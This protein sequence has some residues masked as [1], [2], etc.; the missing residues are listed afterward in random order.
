MNSR[1]PDNGMPVPGQSMKATKGKQLT[2]KKVL[3]EGGQGRV[4]LVDYD[5]SEKAFKW[6][7]LGV[8]PNPNAFRKNLV[9]NAES[10]SPA[11]QF[12]WPID[13]VENDDGRFGYVME[14]RPPE[15]REAIEFFL[16]K[17]YFAN[18]KRAIDACLNVV[19]AFRLLHNKG[20]VYRDINGGNFFINP[21]NGKVLICDND[22]VGDPTIDTGIIGT[23]RFMAPEVV[24]GATEPNTKSD[25]YSMSV[26]LFM[27]LCLN[28]PLEG[29]RSLIPVLDRA[30]QK[31]LYGTDPIFIMDPDNKANPP[32]P[33]VHSNVICM[34]G[35]LPGYMRDLF[36][37]AFSR[38][39]L[40]NPQKRP[41]EFEWINTL[42]RFRSD[43]VACRCGNEVFLD[44]KASSMCEICGRTISPACK[45]K[46]ANYEIPI[47][48]D[49]RIYKCQIAICS[50]DEALKPIAQ[51]IT[52]KD[53]PSFLG[54]LN[55]SDTTWDAV[56][57]SGK[58]KLVQPDD[59][60]PVIPG[61]QFTIEST[62]VQI[63]P[64]QA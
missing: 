23:P 47:A 8:F 60:I 33:Q 34:W 44:E 5:G 40:F 56:T 25:I 54:I 31:M 39:A 29:E 43:I 37:R 58:K 17:V 10:P 63:Q 59:I 26:L 20:F 48:H 15:Y 49:S 6:Y 19:S 55:M 61:I 32:D 21:A 24:T 52:K 13:I 11:R 2:V 18:F 42:V 3:G 53:D 7:K 35:C 46:L 14:L 51:V 1:K 4:F 9:R 30:H 28:H 38:E 41:K 50:P 62:T 12:I 45:L 36:T 57:P 16:H 22:N 27:L 64:N